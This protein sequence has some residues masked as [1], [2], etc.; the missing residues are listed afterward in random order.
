MSTKRVS[1]TTA[2]PTRDTEEELSQIQAETPANGWPPAAEKDSGN[3]N[4]SP[5]GGWNEFPSRKEE[6][7]W[8]QGL[9]VSRY[10][11]T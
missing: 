5:D 7:R 9:E 3:K 2:S 6:T 8:A 1:A 11:L 4:T 10:V